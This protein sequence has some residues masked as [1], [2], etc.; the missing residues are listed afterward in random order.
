VPALEGVTTAPS[1]H[2]ARI[3]GPIAEPAAEAPADAT[4]LTEVLEWHARCHGERVHIVLWHG[5]GKETSLTYGE[6]SL[7]KSAAG[8]VLKQA[9]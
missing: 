6:A 3:R 4:T 5:D 2:D 8:K 7:P 9:L 1:V